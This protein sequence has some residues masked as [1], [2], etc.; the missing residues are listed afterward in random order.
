MATNIK[1]NFQLWTV[2]TVK[3]TGS[4]FT[5]KG[6]INIEEIIFTKVDPRNP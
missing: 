5:Q 3:I 2:K 4:N 1:I 6:K